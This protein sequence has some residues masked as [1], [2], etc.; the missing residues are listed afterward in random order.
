MNETS[1]GHTT[2]Q[3]LLAASQQT[4]IFHLNFQWSLSELERLRFKPGRVQGTPAGMWATSEL[5]PLSS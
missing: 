5:G 2:W 4:P 3:W 1:E